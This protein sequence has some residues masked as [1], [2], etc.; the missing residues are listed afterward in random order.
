MGSEKYKSPNEYMQFISENGGQT[1][2]YTAAQQTTYLF[3]INSDKFP[4]ALDRLSSAIK[5]PYLM[6]TWLKKKLM[7]LILSGY[8]GDNLNPS[9]DQG[10]LL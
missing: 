5:A 10:Q 6:G 9:L 1:N 4:D 8:S 7:R 3:S 2:A